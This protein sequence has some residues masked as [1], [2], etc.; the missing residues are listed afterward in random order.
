MG[1]PSKAS[2][3]GNIEKF[4]IVSDYNDN[5]DISMGVVE[6][7][8]YES[9]L[10]PSV[11]VSSQIIDSGFR[12]DAI[13]K[14]T[15]FEAATANDQNPEGSGDD[16]SITGGEK[17]IL[18]FSDNQG[19]T[20]SFPELRVQQTR[21]I[22]DSN[23]FSSFTIDLCSTESFKNEFAENRVQSHYE[24]KISDSVDKIIKENLKTDNKIEIDPTINE[25]SFNGNTDK[26][27][28]KLCE[29]ATKCVPD[30]IPNALGNIAGYFFWETAVDGEGKRYCF[31]S[32]D[33]LFTQS[34][35]RTLKYTDTPAGTIKDFSFDSSM[36]VKQELMSGTFNTK[37]ISMNPHNQ[38]Y[39]DGDSNR[40]KQEEKGKLGGQEFP[41]IAKD[42]DLN[43]KP[44]A[45][46]NQILD[47]GTL[48][49]GT[50][51][52]SQLSKAKE[53]NFDTSKIQRQA[54]QRYNQLFTYKLVVTIVGDFSLH[55]GDLVLIELPEVNW[56]TNGSLSKLKSGLYMIMDLCH[57]IRTN[58]TF[59]KLN[60]VRDSIFAQ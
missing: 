51:L 54:R 8:Y 39:K 36:D 42:L 14:K 41:K 49:P 55:A 47:T 11:R 21:N 45:I 29:T 12:K 25:L 37:Q 60:L 22:S 26:P 15:G 28:Y 32:I 6:L 1:S 24:G 10:D 35:K 4:I 3:S 31:K 59:T 27:F 17:V 58:D 5:L 40:K 18:S 34:P 30:G 13:R 43:N 2:E 23:Q 20:L 38:E 16:T 46:N 44:T 52:K 7:H 19:T 9:M 53:V 50:N 56:E 33:K 57:L 48:P